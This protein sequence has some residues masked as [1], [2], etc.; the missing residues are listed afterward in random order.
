M[1][2]DPPAHAARR[3]E[4]ARA[5]HPGLPPQTERVGVL[6]RMEQTGCVERYRNA[7]D[8]RRVHVRLTAWG[9]ACFA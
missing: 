4:K 3:Y 5:G 2:G 1:V 9:E 6:A 7:R 8:A